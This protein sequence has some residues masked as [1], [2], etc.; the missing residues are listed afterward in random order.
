MLRHGSSESFAPAGAAQ[1]GF[2]RALSAQ[3]FVE[4]LRPPCLR[5]FWVGQEFRPRIEVGPRA[6]NR[7]QRPAKPA[8]RGRS[9]AGGETWMPATLPLYVTRPSASRS[10]PRDY[11][12]NFSMYANA[13]RSNG[14]SITAASPLF[15]P[16]RPRPAGGLP[17]CRTGSRR[18]FWIR[19]Q[20]GARSR[21]QAARRLA[22]GALRNICPGFS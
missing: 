21:R 20:I 4:A 15:Y 1:G 12:C 2:S 3:Q 14:R 9:N 22:A 13:Q 11:V 17:V 16:L 18:V 5:W 8:C 6:I 19:R 7:Q 10:T